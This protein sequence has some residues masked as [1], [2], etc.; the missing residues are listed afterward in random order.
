[1]T[2]LNLH[3]NS[4][5]SYMDKPGMSIKK[6]APPQLSRVVT[7]E[8]FVI[9]ST[10][11]TSGKTAESALPVIN[12][13]PET[14]TNTKLPKINPRKE[15]P[16]PEITIKIASAANSTLPTAKKN[17]PQSPLTPQPPK[18]PKSPIS[19][20]LPSTPP[21]STTKSLSPTPPL[22]KLPA[23]N[24][25]RLRGI[26]P[27]E[28]K[29]PPIAPLSKPLS[30][31]FDPAD[32]V[33]VLKS[34]KLNT[35]GVQPK[36]GAN[37]IVEIHRNFVLKADSSEIIRTEYLLNI[38]LK[39]CSLEVP[40]SHMLNKDQVAELKTYSP[41]Y[42]QEDK[43]VMIMAKVK[44]TTFQDLIE[45][46]N[47]KKQFN[48]GIKQR[49]KDIG[50][51]AAFDMLIGNSDR[52]ISLRPDL[53]EGLGPYPMANLGNW[54]YT[55]NQGKI[56]KNL[57]AIDNGCVNTPGDDLPETMENYVGVFAN[58]I[59]NKQKDVA[60]HILIRKLVKDTFNEGRKSPITYDDLLTNVIEGLKQGM[61]EIKK[62]GNNETLQ[63]LITNSISPEERRLFEMI[64][65]R[66]RSLTEPTD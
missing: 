55:I 46:P 48:K 33:K 13:T 12:R 16:L 14:P 21:P 49:M 38:Y 41:R 64:A 22:N 53:K 35:D 58:Y 37:G 47:L 19:R 27:V 34:S 3:F 40:E 60:D 44:G 20:P 6:T 25:L 45:D 50:R 9:S 5:E 51:L 66:L 7:E 54:M 36:R 10:N 32:F 61:E 52:F 23:N 18:H 1:M 65:A 31:Q 62:S 42:N 26:S 24:P 39:S 8:T 4:G 28:P 15:E 63:G 56:D 29:K 11:R 59:K 30:L 43:D 57:V 17:L 2:S